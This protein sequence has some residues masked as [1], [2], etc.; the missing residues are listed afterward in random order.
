MIS[1]VHSF[2]FDLPFYL[3]LP[4]AVFLVWD[5]G[6]RCA[7]LLPRQRL[8]EVA[9]AKTTQLVSEDRLVDAR[10]PA[11]YAAP[12][13]G[14]AMVCETPDYGTIP[15]LRI[16]TGPDGGCAELRPFT[17]VCVFVSDAVAADA[18]LPRVF[19]ILN[20]FIGRIGWSLRILG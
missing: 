20:N 2:R 5:P 7:G 11:P 8:G 18:Q 19:A 4:G 12:R 3:R 16:D 10:V 1:E 13:H 14:V 17:E 6:D 9:F 15:T